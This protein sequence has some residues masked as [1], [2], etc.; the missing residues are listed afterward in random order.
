MK[1]IQS[2]VAILVASLPL[3]GAP[4]HVCAQT[5]PIKPIR[6]I[7]PLAPGGGTDIVGRTIAQ[8]L[9]E[10]LSQSVIVENRAGAGGNIGMEAAA[11]AP[12][13]GYTVIVTTTGLAS[14]PSLYDKVPFDPI[15]DF[16]PVTFLGL[17]PFILVVHPSVPANSVNHLLA[18]A[19]SRPGQLNFASAGNGSGSHLS[20]ELFNSMT[21]VQMVNVSYKGGGP[22]LIDLLGGQVSLMFQS[23]PVALPYVKVGKLRA[24]AVTT[25]L[26]ASV[27][28][29]IPT[30]SESGVPGFE[31]V[32]WYGLFAP[33][34][35]SKEIVAKLNAELNTILR[36]QDV[37]SRFEVLGIEPVGSTPEELE[38]HLKSEFSKWAKVI[39]A[40][41][42]KAE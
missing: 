29:S 24:L 33:A 38:L 34:R 27:A 15:R 7:V 20:A 2:R 32:L 21:R 36:T 4:L 16:S 39:K 8:K 28:P 17:G 22:A 41:G 42:I 26:R 14:N 5:Y 1:T 30:I 37:R 40:A 19:R 9:S 3:C 11:K 25:S 18:L 6:I 35:T 23:M 12:P 31:V 10:S 13:D